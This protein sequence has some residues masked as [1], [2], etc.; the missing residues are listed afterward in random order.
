MP[1]PTQAY[2]V[3]VRGTLADGQISTF[4]ALFTPLVSRL[5]WV[6]AAD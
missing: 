2:I 6:L 3:L 4:K 5:A 1:P